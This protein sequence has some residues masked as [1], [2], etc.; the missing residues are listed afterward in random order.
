V[1][2]DCQSEPAHEARRDDEVNMNGNQTALTFDEV[3]T[4]KAAIR[5]IR[6]LTVLTT[7]VALP[8]VVVLATP[9]IGWALLTAILFSP[10]IL[11]YVLVAASRQAEA[12]RRQARA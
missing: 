11:G 1:R 5:V 7:A 12:E 2:V 3:S 10:L 8:V 6:Y 4:A 9:L